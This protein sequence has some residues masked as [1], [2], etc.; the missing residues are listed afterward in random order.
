MRTLYLKD[1]TF[2]GC[3]A[4]DDGV[5][6][7]LVKRIESGAIK[8]LVAAEFPLEEIV[9]AQEMFLAKQFTGKIVLQVS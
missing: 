6:E 9:S 7:A 4:L 2:Y 3:T 8:P 1:L 5:F